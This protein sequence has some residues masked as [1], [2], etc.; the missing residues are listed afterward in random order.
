MG[1]LVEPGD[2]LLPFGR[3]EILS[4]RKKNSRPVGV[5]D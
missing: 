5:Q 1:M 4:F 3:Q 2:L